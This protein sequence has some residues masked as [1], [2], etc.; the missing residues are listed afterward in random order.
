M[1]IIGGQGAKLLTRYFHTSSFGLELTDA[2]FQMD[3]IAMNVGSAVTPTGTTLEEEQIT[4]TTAETITVSGTP[5]D[6][7]GYGT[8]GWYAEPGSTEWTMFTFSSGSTATGVSG[9]AANTTYCVKYINNVQCD[10]VIINGD[11]VPSEVTVILKGKLF[12]AGK[13]NEVDVTSSS[14]IGVVEVEVPRFQLNGSMDLTLNMTGASQTPFSGQ[15]L[16][17]QDASAGCDSGGYYAKIKRIDLNSSWYDNLVAITPV[18][19]DQ[20]TMATD[21]TTPLVVYGVFSGNVAS[22]RIDPANL[23]YTPSGSGGATVD[24]T[25]GVISAGSTTGNTVITVTVKDATGSAAQISTQA[26]VTVS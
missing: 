8:I 12:R 9:V 18:P 16:L 4:T 23:T 22:K 11:F 21:S 17:T 6:F 15:A 1:N 5:A 24:A 14:Q 7:M 19:T 3:Y 20:I 13:D 10:E 2:L 26:T 25:T